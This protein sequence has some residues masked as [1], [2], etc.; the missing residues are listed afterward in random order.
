MFS[1]VVY[2]RLTDAQLDVVSGL[3]VALTVLPQGLA[4][5]TIANLPQQVC[6][7]NN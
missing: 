1:I 2:F 5:A 6:T 3:T 4:Y 7:K